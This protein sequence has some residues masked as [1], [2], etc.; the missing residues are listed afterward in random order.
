MPAPGMQQNSEAENERRPKVLIA[1]AKRIGEI[2]QESVKSQDALIAVA[3]GIFESAKEGAGGHGSI[4]DHAE[5]LFGQ[6]APAP[7]GS[8]SQCNQDLKDFELASAAAGK[9]GN[10]TPAEEAWNNYTHCIRTLRI[11]PI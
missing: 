6:S 5:K 8:L 2:Q 4:L 7:A 10:W 9:S 3:K 1:L 11:I